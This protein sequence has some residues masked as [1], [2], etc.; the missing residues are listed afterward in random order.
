MKDTSKRAALT[1]SLTFAYSDRH[2][3][4]IDS[5]GTRRGRVGKGI[6]FI[7]ILSIMLK[8]FNKMYWV[9]LGKSRRSSLIRLFWVIELSLS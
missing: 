7:M 2:K 3:K 8:L 9:G 4:K 1:A 5:L 6:I